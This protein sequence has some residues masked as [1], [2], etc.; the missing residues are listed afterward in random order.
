[1]IADFTKAVPAGFM[2]CTLGCV[3]CLLVV[4]VLPLPAAEGLSV[5]SRAARVAEPERRAVAETLKKQP[6]AVATPPTRTQVSNA[7]G[8]VPIVSG[9]F[10]KRGTFRIALKQH[11]A[12][13]WN[14]SSHL[15]RSLLQVTAKSA[16]LRSASNALGGPPPDKIFG[17]I[18]VGTPPKEFS[19]AFDTGSGD[20]ILPARNC[21]SMPCISHRSYDSFASATSSPISTPVHVAR[22]GGLPMKLMVST[23]QVSGNLRQD[24]VC[25]GSEDNLCSTVGLVEAT[26]MSEEPFGLLPFDGIMGLGLT[27]SSLGKPFNFMGMLADHEALAS[28]KFAVWLAMEADNEDSEITFG[29]A[30]SARQD[31]EVVWLP[32]EQPSG[33]WQVKMDDFTVNM[34]KTKFCGVGGCKAA[35]DTAGG[36]IAGPPAVINALALVL[37]VQPDCSNYKNLPRLGF[38]IGPA[39]FHVEAADYVRKTGAGCYLQMLAYNPPPGKEPLVMLGTPFLRRY[40]TIYDAEAMQVGVALAKH[41]PSNA[42]H[43]LVLNDKHTTGLLQQASADAGPNVAHSLLQQ[44]SANAEG[45]SASMR[46]TKVVPWFLVCTITML[47]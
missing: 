4:A 43:L 42:K 31:S 46:A 37:N 21:P 6:L 13:A 24:K 2:L 44:V 40:Y 8:T 27:N 20:L 28:Y 5:Y 14:D 38:V 45:E 33:L 35:F 39:T 15:P 12:K 3:T 25:L 47:S 10:P 29:V 23:G 7:V 30:S 36:V 19:V 9:T 17:T 32:V 34:V 16:A 41:V 26:R 18:Y 11:P 1:L 22:L